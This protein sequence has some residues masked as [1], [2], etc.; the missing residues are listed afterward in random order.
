MRSKLLDLF[1]S[2][3]GAAPRRNELKKTVSSLIFKSFKNRTGTFLQSVYSRVLIFFVVG[4]DKDDC[5]FTMIS[6][7]LDGG[8]TQSA[9][10]IRNCQCYND[11]YLVYQTVG[12]SG[13]TQNCPN[14]KATSRGLFLIGELILAIC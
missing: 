13:T 8:Y 5:G 2:T 14:V 9:S 1:F 4:L 7:D 11:V 10:P 12:L 3:S 6:Q